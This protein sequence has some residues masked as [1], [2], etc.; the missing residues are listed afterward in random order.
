MLETLYALRKKYLESFSLIQVEATFV[1]ESKAYVSNV[2]LTPKV[3]LQTY[4]P[5]SKISTFKSSSNYISII[6]LA[7]MLT[8]ESIYNG[9][10]IA[11]WL[12][13]KSR[14]FWFLSC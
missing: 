2:L 9:H 8:L 12:Y 10:A 11:K 7:A 4:K 1:L 13:L 3:F 5:S 6:F 14:A